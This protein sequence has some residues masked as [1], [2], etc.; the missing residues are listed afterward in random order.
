TTLSTF[1]TLCTRSFL[2][3]PTPLPISIRN[4]QSARM[5]LFVVLASLLAALAAAQTETYG[6]H[7]RRSAHVVNL[8]SL[9]PTTLVTSAALPQWTCNPATC[10][11]LPN[12]LPTFTGSWPTITDSIAIVTVTESL[13][14][15]TSTN[16]LD[17]NDKRV[18]ECIKKVC[19]G[20]MFGC[21]CVKFKTIDG[22]EYDTGFAGFAK[23]DGIAINHH[24]DAMTRDVVLS[25]KR[26]GD[27][28]GKGVEAKRIPEC[29]K[30]VCAG[31]KFG[32][33]CVKWKTA[34]GEK[35]TDT[36]DAR[37]RCYRKGRRGEEFQC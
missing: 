1:V 22:Q 17:T 31:P 16:S 6:A 2:P 12:E 3:Q 14:E 15:P 5:I 7:P 34:D 13:P 10:V 4:L 23:R 19:A 35:S 30:Q 36:I 27:E 32:C 11:Q 24:F 8:H 20:L 9:V 18:P 29:I 28:A 37:G 21:W 25:D 33:W 26:D